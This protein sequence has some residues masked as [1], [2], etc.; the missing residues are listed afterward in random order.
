[1][2]ITFDE[3][4]SADLFSDIELSTSVNIAVNSDCKD[5]LVYCVR[6]SCA[7]CTFNTHIFNFSKRAPC[8][9]ALTNQSPLTIYR[10]GKV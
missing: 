6:F 10:N 7:C 9:L 4:L 5:S 3:E 8:Q 2:D 1:M